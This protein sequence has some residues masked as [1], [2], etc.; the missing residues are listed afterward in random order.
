MLNFSKREAQ[1]AEPKPD[2]YSWDAESL[3]SVFPICGCGARSVIVKVPPAP[4]GEQ[5][6]VPL[7]PQ[8]D[9]ADRQ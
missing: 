3:V 5:V 4:R 1:P 2:Y 6:P 9:I 7:C 8:C